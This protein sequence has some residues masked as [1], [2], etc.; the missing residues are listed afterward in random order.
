[1]S[2]IN[3]K[4]FL[5]DHTMLDGVQRRE[6]LGELR[7]KAGKMYMSSEELILATAIA[8]KAAR[9]AGRY[10]LENLGSAQIQ[11]EKS[12]ND[13]LL[14]VDL[15][16]ERIIL[17]QL[18]VAFPTYG[19]LSEEAGLFGDEEAYWVVD[20]LDGSSNFQ[21]GNPQFGVAIA[22]VQQR[23]TVL[24]IIYIP[25]YDELFTALLGKGAT[26]DGNPIH[27]SEN[28]NLNMSLIHSGG[29]TKSGDPHGNSLRTIELERIANGAKQLRITGTSA[30]DFVSLACGRAD[31]LV[32][33]MTSAWDI[34]AGELLVTEAGGRFS[35]HQGEEP[36]KVRIYSNGYIHD[37]LVALVVS[38]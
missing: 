9:D 1:M 23:K 13:Y 26:L 34:N 32:S 21:H 20:P 8:E 15:G 22:L 6:F 31:G 17:P 11:Y 37:E 33:H 14:D 4:T 18:Q 35:V 19:I 28:R 38:Q 7:K 30:L 3:C 5:S 16:A 27:V 25:T 2:D 29:F 36:K 10:L 12:A 24:G